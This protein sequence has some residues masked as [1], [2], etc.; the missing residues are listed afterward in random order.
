MRLRDRRITGSLL[1]ASLAPD[2]VRV[3]LK[4]TRQRVLEKDTSPSGL[5]VHVSVHTQM[6]SHK[7]IYANT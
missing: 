5:H 4:E 3:S 7:H 6:C 1:V 2:L